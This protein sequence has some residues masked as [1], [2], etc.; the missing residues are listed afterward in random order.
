MIEIKTFASGSS[1]N[2]YKITDGET[3]LM[4]ETGLTIKKIKEAFDFKLS[5][6]SGCLISH[7]HSD[8]SKGIKGM[9]KAG[10]NCYMSEGTKEAL[11]VS[12]HRVKS[13]KSKELFEIGTFKILPFDTQHDCSE[14]YGFL[15][16]SGDEKLLFATDT[17]YLKYKFSG[18]NYIMI[19]CN[20]SK[21][22]L[23]ESIKSGLTPAALKNRI[24]KSHFE[25]ENVK[26]FFRQ[27][28][29]SNVKEIHLLH[30]SS[31]NGHDEFFK[32]E[33]QEFTGKPVC[34]K[35]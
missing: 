3:I 22:I 14:P 31:N 10:I 18:L 35:K 12:G 15:I 25:L 13:V 32:N 23:E 4:I 28:D 5:D 11:N 7:E 2:L 19:E 34:V 30:I 17:F 1:G 16:Q 33:I 20:Y 26:E 8:H 24:T 27:N 9:I 21:K 29:L 6:V